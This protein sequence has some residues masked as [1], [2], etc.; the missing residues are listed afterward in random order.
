M[1]NQFFILYIKQTR[2][3]VAKRD[4][5]TYHRIIFIMM[6]FYHSLVLIPSIRIIELILL[7][8]DILNLF[9]DD[10]KHVFS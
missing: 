7:R 4:C 10:E 6:F 5:F 1:N 2:V 8:H 9:F 3:C